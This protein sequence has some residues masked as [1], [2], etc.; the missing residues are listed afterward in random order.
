M[1]LSGE[2]FQNEDCVIAACEK[3]PPVPVETVTEAPM[4]ASGEHIS[5]L[6][7]PLGENMKLHAEIRYFH[8][9]IRGLKIWPTIRRTIVLFSYSP[10]GSRNCNDIFVD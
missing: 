4:E 7:L 1:L 9:T 5:N 10:C 6:R 3:R 8:N 2:H